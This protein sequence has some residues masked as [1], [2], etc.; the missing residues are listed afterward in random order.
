MLPFAPNASPVSPADPMRRYL[1]PLLALCFLLSV[2]P[3]AR[4]A[5]A[6]PAEA[7]VDYNRQVR[8]I[9]SNHCYACHGPD[10]AQLQAGLRLDKRDAALA[11]L[12]SGGHAI[13]PGDSAASKLVARITSADPDE[14]MPPADAGKPLTAEQIAILRRWID[15][16]AKWQD[17]W[18]YQSVT[19]PTMPPVANAAWP[20]TPLD[21]FVLR[22]LEQD[23]LAPEPEADRAT[24]VRRLSF[25]LTGLPPNA[26]EV[27]AFVA[28]DRSDAYERL[29]DRLLASPRYGERMAQKWLDLARYADTNGYHIDNHRDIWLYRNWVIDAFNRNLPFDQFAVE[30]LAGDLLPNPTLE[31]RIATGFHR[32][33]M[34]NFEGGADPAEY[35]S[36]YIVDR[37]TTT[38]TV[39]L[40]STLAC[41]E[42]HDHKYDPFTQREF[43]QLYAYFN[44]VPEKGLDGNQSNPV[45]SI[46][47]P[48]ETQ[49]R[50]LA[51]LDANRAA[52]EQRAAAEVVRYRA[53]D[54]PNQ[55]AAAVGVPREYV[56]VDDEIPAGSTSS[57]KDADGWQFVESPHPVLQ[58]KRASHRRADGLS[59]HFFTGASEP[60]LIGE[61]DKLVAHV[62][63]DPASPPQEIMLQFNDGGNWDHRAY[64]G[65]NAIEWG[66]ADSPSRRS[67][68][69]LPAAGRWIRL[70]VDAATVGL[71]AGSTI[72]G[73][74]CTQ[75]GGHVYWDRL[76][77]LT[78]MPQGSSVNENQGTWELAER[79][80]AKST[81]PE[82]VQAA[83]KIP[84]AERTDEQRHVVRDYFVRHFYTG[85][86]PVFAPI[87]G[88]LAAV[89]KEQ[90]EVRKKF[91]A[92][93]VMEEM[94]A[95]RETFVLVRGDFRTQ[96]DPVKPGVPAALSPLP[97]G[98]PANRLGLAKWLVDPANP[99][100]A[101]V[102]VNRYWQQYFGVGLVKTSE[103]FGSQGETP[104]HPD[105]LDWLAARFIDSGWNVKELQKLIVMSAVYRQSSR[106]APEKQARDPHNRLLARGPRFRLDAEMIR[107]NALA[108]SGL[109][110]DR[111]GGPSV[112]PYQPPGLWEQVG[113]GGEFTSQSYTQSH[114]RDLYRRGIYVYLKRAMP[115]PPLVTFDAPNREVCTDNR[116]RTNTPL[117]ALVLLNDPGFVEAARV[118]AQRIV[119]SG[120][121]S[122]SERL[123]Y[124]F[125]LCTSRTPQPAEAQV[126][127]EIY[128][129][130]LARFKQDPA[131]A[132]QLTAIGESPLPA[133]LD[134]AEVAA[135][136]AVGNVLLNLDETITKG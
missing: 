4:A 63:I 82:A 43:Y 100:V 95:P 79:G 113:F 105:L 96:G 135:W 60:L 26:A 90:D 37:V 126:L 17:H 51:E 108:V 76:G 52:I 12:E 114:G 92:T 77:I 42:C 99:L 93:M 111:I 109:L 116:A 74:A 131:A 69:T 64:W 45:P 15:E 94:P 106:I 59:Q 101:R 102:T 1:S 66:Q 44:N 132:K 70:E 7:P 23:S 29:V 20:R 19:A 35:L 65:N 11:A 119:T 41:T 72:D 67:M 73:W 3:W 32:N 130:Q 89:T 86:R 104:S 36:K 110:D 48:Q 46:Q 57:G 10:Q 6:P 75:F 55:P 39:F 25:D 31:Q 84:A 128:E 38:A 21:Y 18:S 125:K 40:G 62:W 53:I 103:D 118:M 2:A 14:V 28:D 30:Q 13:L 16:G 107:D 49:T 85:A 58:G 123:D 122:P 54:V 9:L 27:D 115:Y 88:E 5:D 50:R 22:R 98:A 112:A 80:R 33:T 78:R 83:I 120:G 71:P 117:Q 47:V 91:P 134:P 81:A 61:G 87:E 133:N 8:Q 56:W 127:L 68:G 136:T 97:D 121:S 129:T 124:A 24:L 34:V